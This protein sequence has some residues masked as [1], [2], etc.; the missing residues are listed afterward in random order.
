MKE[1]RENKKKEKQRSKRQVGDHKESS[2]SHG[3]RESQLEESKNELVVKQSQL[4]KI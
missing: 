1:Q 3:I 2:T 4:N